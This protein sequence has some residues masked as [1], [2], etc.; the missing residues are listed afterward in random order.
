MSGKINVQIKNLPQ[1][2]AAF[3]LAPMLMATELDK[4]ISKSIY[5]IQR[6]SMAATPVD[7]G[8][9]R[10]SHKSTFAPLKGVLDVTAYYGIYVH[11]GTR[12]MKP[13][14]FLLDS[15]NS[16]ER[17]VDDNFTK[18]VDNVLSKLADSGK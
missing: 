15:V 3:R 12:Y 16:N 13:R 4:A 7:T 9:L 11:E 10:A 1:I 8:R 17:Q 2:R 14:P 18:A 6:G 5:A